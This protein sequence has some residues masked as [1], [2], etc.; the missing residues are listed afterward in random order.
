MALHIGII[1]TRGIP[2][3]YGGFEEC[4][5]QLAVQ[6]TKMGHRVTVYNSHRHP[7]EHKTFQGVHIL[8]KYD[9][10]HRLGTAGQ[11]IY[12]L[13]CFWDA[14]QRPFD[15]LLN[16]G[17]TSS[18]PWL[19]L[20]SQQMPVVTNMDG[21]EWQRAKYGPYAK[22]YLRW[23]E[24]W[25][26]RR[27]QVLVADAQEIQRYLQEQYGS[28]P[29][30]IP[31]GAHP[32][33]KPSEEALQ[34]FNV[35]PGSYNLIV[36]RL[37][38]ENNLEVILEGVQKSHSQRVML[39]VGHHESP[40]G[41]YLKTRFRDSR[42][43]FVKGTFRKERINNLRYHA[44]LYF[45]GHSA[46]GTNPSLLEAMGC[47]CMIVAH[48]NPFNREVLG[49]AG[50]YF[51]DASDVVNALDHLDRNEIQK[52]HIQ[53]NIEK[54]KTQYAWPLVAEQYEVTLEQA[55]LS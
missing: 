12:D 31:Y 51:I 26:A 45:H 52:R 39:V 40:Y 8:H 3:Y 18:A 46:G 35:Q 53:A 55:R 37:V 19:P 14:R 13:N 15:V 43:R 6:L 22:R 1:G 10:E 48:Q 20:V 9:P 4:A 2:N 24:R 16:L 21:L 34:R 25:A 23:A 41:N 54:I 30:Y 50:N 11:W 42:I 36:A 38:P 28:Q 44:H 49:E 27:S 5:Q 33:R 32:F 7:Y 17:Y 47:R 29:V